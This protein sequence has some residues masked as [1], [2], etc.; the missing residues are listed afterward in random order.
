MMDPSWRECPV[1][2]A[3]VTGWLVLLDEK[4][5]SRNVIYTMHEGKS[6]IGTGLDCE[7]RILLNSISRHHAMISYSSGHYTL[8]D[9]GSSGGTYINN[10]QVSNHNIIDGDILRLGAV[11]LKFKCI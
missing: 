4:K 11:E 2:L 7:V 8:T 10:R 3:P 6:K 9:L 5:K 1:C